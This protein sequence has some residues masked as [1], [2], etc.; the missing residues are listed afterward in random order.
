MLYNQTTILITLHLH[1]RLLKI[2]KCNTTEL[3]NNSTF[4][5]IGVGTYSRLRGPEIQSR[6]Q[7]TRKFMTMPTFHSN[8]AHFCTSKAVRQRFLT[9]TTSCKSTRAYFVTLHEFL[10]DGSVRPGMLLLNYLCIL[11]D[12]GLSGY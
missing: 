6:A 2:A 5:S 12:F 3:Y 4:H 10:S 1:N 7:C 11:A 8:H 9:H